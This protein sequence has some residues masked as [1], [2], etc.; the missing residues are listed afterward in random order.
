MNDA[1]Y[2]LTEQLRSMNET[3]A[4]EFANRYLDKNT[5]EENAEYLKKAIHAKDNTSELALE[6]ALKGSHLAQFTYAMSLI[7]PKNP[8]QEI[9]Q[10]IF[11]LKRA[12]NN[13]STKASTILASLY[14]PDS[15][16]A[17]GTLAPA[18]QKAI[19]YIHHAAMRGD[20]TAQLIYAELY[21][22][23]Q[24]VPADDDAAT[25]WL[26]HS[27]SRGNKKALAYLQHAGIEVKL[28]E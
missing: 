1:Y 2:N 13:G 20:D 24:G 4:M 27:A 10:A 16:V 6:Y 19:E 23:G 15:G 8:A 25:Y 28:P 18:P 5:S 22:K 9:T 17:P 3:E 12:H 21:M 7:S 11:W 26:Q 14:L